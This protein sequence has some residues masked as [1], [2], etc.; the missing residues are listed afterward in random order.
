MPN[1]SS[2]FILWDK[3]I[4]YPFFDLILRDTDPG[5]VF[6]LS[7]DLNDYNG[8]VYITAKHIIEMGTSIGMA[9]IEEVARLNAHIESLEAQIG[10]LPTAQK[11]LK[12][13]LASLVSKFHSDLLNDTLDIPPSVEEPAEIDPEPIEP[14]RD[15]R[16]AFSL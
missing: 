15:T 13:G 9:S 10:R 12:D 11:D 5:P 8:S 1:I 4:A 2:R 14:E 16:D 6:D 3:P 7:V